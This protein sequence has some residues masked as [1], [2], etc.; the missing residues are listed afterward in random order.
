M[1]DN[2]EIDSSSSDEEKTVMEPKESQVALVSFQS[3]LE[4][5][6]EQ[7][8]DVRMEMSTCKQQLKSVMRAVNEKGIDIDDIPS[9][10]G[11]AQGGMHGSCAPMGGTQGFGA[12]SAHAERAALKMNTGPVLA[13]GAPGHGGTDVPLTEMKTTDAGRGVNTVQENLLRLQKSLK[14]EA[15]DEVAGMLINPANVEHIMGRLEF[16]YGQTELL[17]RSQLEK[18]SEI[19]QIFENSLDKIVPFSSKVANLIIFLETANAAQ[20]LNNPVL[21]S[22]LVNKLPIRIRIDWSRYAACIR[23]YPNIKNFGDWINQMAM[24]VS[25]ATLATASSKQ[26]GK[27]DQRSNQKT[28]MQTSTDAPHK[29]EQNGCFKCKGNHILEKCESFSKETIEDR[30]T[31]VKKAYL[32]YGCLRQGH[33]LKS[34]KKKQECGISDCKSYHHHLLHKNKSNPSNVEQKE[35]PKHQATETVNTIKAGTSKLLFKV[36][37]VEVTGPNGIIVETFAFVDEGSSATLINENLAKNMGINQPKEKLSLNWIGSYTKDVQSMRCQFRIRSA[38]SSKRWLRLMGNTVPNMNLPLQSLNAD[39]LTAQFE[40]MK[41]LSIMGYEKAEPMLLIGIDNVHLTKTFKSTCLG[42]DLVAA[43]TP[44]GWL[45]YGSTQAQE[46]LPFASE[47]EAYDISKEVT[48]VHRLANFELRGFVSNSPTVQRSLNNED[49]NEVQTAVQLDNKAV[50]KILGMFWESQQDILIFDLKMNRVDKD[51]VKGVKRPT[52]RQLLSLVMSVYDPFGMLADLMIYGKI[53]VQDVWRTGICWNDLIPDALFE[54]FVQWLRQL[55]NVKYFKIPR[56]YSPKFLLQDTSIELHVFVDASEQAFAAVAYWR[57]VVGN[58][59]ETSFVA[60]KTRCAPLKLLSVPRLE[61]QAAVLG[62]RLRTSIL[63]SHDIIYKQF[64]AHRISEILDTTN[65]NDWRWVPTQ[66]N[67][68]DKATK[69]NKNLNYEPQTIWTKG[70]NFLMETESLWPSQEKLIAPIND[71]AEKRKI[72]LHASSDLLFDIGRFSRYVRLKRTVGWMLRFVERTR[73]PEKITATGELTFAELRQAELILCK[74]V[75]AQTFEEEI[76]VLTLKGLI[77]KS[78]A[79]YS[80]SPELNEHGVLVVHGRLDYATVLPQRARQPIIL[81]KGHG[82]TN[83][84]VQHYHEIYHHQND[85]LIVNEIRPQQLK[86]N[87]WRRWIREYLPTLTRRTKWFTPAK[88]IK[89]GDVVLI[90]DENQPRGSWKRGVVIQPIQAKDG[91]I[92]IVEIQ[93][94]TGILKRPISKLAILDVLGRC[95]CLANC[96]NKSAAETLQGCQ[97]C[98]KDCGKDC[99]EDAATSGATQSRRKRKPLSS[100]GTKSSASTRHFALLSERPLIRNR[101]RHL[102]DFGLHN[103][104]DK[105]PVPGINVSNGQMC[106]RSAVILLDVRTA[107]SCSL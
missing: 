94:T 37:P 81:P 25:R 48:R 93:T 1:A 99:G 86:D 54:R 61:L 73:N 40:R 42:E 103:L 70:P 17:I 100:S 60:G 2:D 83:L 30:W 96:V 19:P 45:V 34:C 69:T 68:A 107:R 7:M 26:H 28:L 4:K 21:L 90:C 74:L 43:K 77:S 106:L 101:R 52:K 67:P 88:P 79:I 57:I 72:I 65:E 15:K 22:D 11:A 8:A 82:L 23:P 63:E 49:D 78:S 98:G 64:V 18:I 3:T 58:D 76:S 35:T 92:R 59:V 39:S 104:S 89:T 46:S 66:L 71:S 97:D 84:I 91:Q 29:I 62:T 36:L 51:I 56:C 13:N 31:L 9:T 10:S 41:Q 27:G 85:E 95:A 102:F 47:Q 24:D 53:L 6:L 50:D 80:L 55:D 105:L 14:G 5:I 87:F 32:C 20:H 44:L 38:G 75:Q 33:S 16:K 12:A